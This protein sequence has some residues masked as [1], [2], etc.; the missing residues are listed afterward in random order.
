MHHL[1]I[2]KRIH[3]R[4][5]GFIFGFTYW[6]QHHRLI[7][8][9]STLVKLLAFVPLVLVWRQNK[10][11]AILTLALLF[12]I[13]VS[14]LYWRARRLGYKTFVASESLLH[15]RDTLEPLPPDQRVRL[16]A[17]GI[18][19]V[20]DREEQVLMQPAEY[21]RV[22]LGDH[23][24]MVQPEPDRF[25]Y[26]FF[27]ADKLQHLQPGWLICGLTPQEVLAVTFYSDWGKETLSLRDLYQG[28]DENN[29]DKKLRTIYLA[30]D[31]KED[32]RAVWYT[33][34]STARVK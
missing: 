5:Q 34:A 27:N 16:K 25:L 14:W 12:G 28:S 17:S 20:S 30:F 31:D 22:P 18:F 19:G 33:I 10:N 4:I 9:F 2:A 6:T 29:Q 24:V 32:E 23:T 7:I 8:R 3:Y 21:W 1:P 15:S 11:A 13:W 26:Q